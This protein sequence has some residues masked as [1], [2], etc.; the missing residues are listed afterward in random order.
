ML[1]DSHNQLGS[2]QLISTV[3]LEDKPG[4]VNDE[5]THTDEEISSTSNPQTSQ[6]Y[7]TLAPSQLDSNSNI[8]SEDSVSVTEVSENTEIPHKPIENVVSTDSEN[9]AQVTTVYLETIDNDKPVN[10]DP[11]SENEKPAV[12]DKP[13]EYEKLE[14]N[15]KPTESDQLTENYKPTEINQP[16]KNQNPTEN[17]EDDSTTASYVTDDLSIT[18]KPETINNIV[19]QNVLINTANESQDLV[20]STQVPE[21]YEPVVT[22]VTPTSDQNRP[23]QNSESDVSITVTTYKPA[24]SALDQQQVDTDNKAS[25]GENNPSVNEDSN[26]KPVEGVMDLS[27]SEINPSEVGTQVPTIVADEKPMVPDN[28]VG[29]LRPTSIDDII[30]SVYLVKDAVKNSL[31]TS[32]K[33]PET[34]DQQVGLFEDD[35]QPTIKPENYPQDQY[36]NEPQTTVSSV[37]AQPESQQTDKVNEMSPEIPSSTTGSNVSQSSENAADG[38]MEATQI[39]NISPQ[40]GVNSADQE[41]STDLPSKHPLVETAVDD[42]KTPVE[43]PTTQRL[44]SIGE[45]DLTNDNG[46]ENPSDSILPHGQNAAKPIS[47]SPEVAVVVNDNKTPE[48]SSPSSEHHEVPVEDTAVEDKPVTEEK[49]DD[50]NSQLTPDSDVPAEV[51]SQVAVIGQ[52]EANTPDDNDNRFNEPS[53]SSF[54]PSAQGGNV[55]NHYNGHPRPETVGAVHIPLDTEPSAFNPSTN[56]PLA[57]YPQKT[58]YTPIPQSTWTQKPF[59]QD[60]TSE[61]PLQPDQGFPDEYDDENDASYGSGTCR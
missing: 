14:E 51:P 9:D 34:S 24:D 5:K 30:S 53:S 45:Q 47:N 58:S 17:S 40:S 19:E 33:P 48:I 46:T 49:P 26:T 35:N 2:P 7:N 28:N 13:E 60:S 6:E 31:E 8:N 22:N 4:E 12:N 23:E 3:V 54:R 36:N 25:E 50:V 41:V 16:I 21:N 32:S 20:P 10:S 15:I 57:T 52:P 42:G 55:N 44:P 56:A 39:P 43:S 1:F 59:H 18:N 61:A 38:V 29:S 27:V 11:S 37:N